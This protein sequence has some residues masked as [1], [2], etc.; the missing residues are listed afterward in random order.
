MYKNKLNEI[1]FKTI[2]SNQPYRNIDKK[3]IENSVNFVAKNENM[4]LLFEVLSKK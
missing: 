1:N 2:S 3:E 4:K